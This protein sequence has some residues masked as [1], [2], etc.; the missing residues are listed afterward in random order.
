MI[1]DDALFEKIEIFHHFRKD[2]NL[3][4]ITPSVVLDSP[5]SATL[6]ASYFVDSFEMIESARV[7]VEKGEN[8]V[9]F[10]Q[11]V[12][13]INPL[14]WNPHSLG[15][16]A[17]YELKTV[18]Y[19]NARAHFVIVQMTGLRETEL[20][21]RA[22]KFFLAVNGKELPCRYHAF[23]PESTTSEVIE[24]SRKYHFDF[25]LLKGSEG[26]KAEKLLDLCDRAGIA[27]CLDITDMD[28]R[29]YDKIALHPCICLHAAEKGKHSK[30][31][32]DFPFLT[33]AQV[34]ESFLNDSSK[35]TK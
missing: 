9:P 34:R 21:R 26:K 1:P 14:I 32:P 6:I 11:K 20:Y 18:F 29:Q 22:G 28:K 19:K 35:G 13:I 3:L 24:F 15:E 30:F 33:L 25:T 23:S 27:V 7:S 5:E 31:A 8:T 12:R 10:R 4:E 17:L 2:G 16:P